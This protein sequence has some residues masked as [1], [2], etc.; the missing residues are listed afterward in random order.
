MRKD[1]SE[2]YCKNKLEKMGCK[3][4]GLNTFTVPK[5]KV[6][7]NGLGMVDFLVNHCKLSVKYV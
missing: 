7:I 6:G 3:F 4:G 1:Y 2:S 5:G